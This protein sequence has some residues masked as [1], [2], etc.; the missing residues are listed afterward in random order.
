SPWAALR[1]H[2][3]VHAL[4]ADKVEVRTVDTE[5]AA[6]LPVSFAPPYRVTLEKG[7]VGELRLGALT[8]AADAEKDP[9]KKRALMDA[10]RDKDLVVKDIALRAEGDEKAWRIHE[11][12]AETPYGKGKLAGSVQTRK[13]FGLDATF[14][15]E[16]VAAER[17]WKAR[18]AAK[19]TLED[20]TANLEGEVSGQPATGSVR[21]EPFAEQPV[22]ALALEARGVDISKHADGP[23]TRLDVNVD[24]TAARKAF[25]GPVRIVNAEPGAWDKG[26][27]PFASAGARVVVTAERLDLHDLEVV[28]A[29][30]GR[31]AGRATV[32]RAGAEANL[33]VSDVNLAALHGNLQPTKVTGRIAATGDTRA[34]HFEVALKDP[35]F[36]I[37][38][39]AQLTPQR[40]D[41]E[42]A[43]VRTSGGAVTAK[44][45][46][47]LAGKREF[48]FEG[49]ARHFDPSAFVKT[50]KGD[51]NFAFVTSGTLS[52]EI[53]GEARLDLTPSTV[54]GLPASGRVN[55]AGD[56]RRVANLDMDVTVGEARAQAKGSF[57]LAGDA[58]DFRFN[59]PNLSTIARPLGVAAAGKVE[60][61]GRLTGTFASPAGRVSLTGANLVL[62]SNVYVRELSARLEAGVEATSPID[63]T[64]RA[65][66]IA[67]G[68]ETPPTP[69][70]QEATV[71]L[72]GTREAHRIEATALM[73]RDA[74]LRAA[75]QGGLDP[76]AK[77]PAWN[78]RVESLALTGAGAFS[79]VQPTTL[80]ASAERVELG[81]AQ[82]KGDW[83]EARFMVTRWTPRTLDLKGSS[84]GIQVQNFARSFRFATVPRSDLVVAVDW[85][86]HAAEQLDASAHLRRVS[87]D[88]RV[89]EPTLPLG[90]ETLEAKVEVV[91]GRAQASV[92]MIG[93]RV[94]KIEGSGST[95]LGHSAN[96]WRP[97]PDAPIEAKL[98]AEHTNLEALAPWLGPDARIGGRLNATVLVE[99]TGA[100]PRVSGTA[101]AVDLAVREP[102][103]GFEVERGQIA[104]KLTG[105]SAVI[106]QFEAVTPWRPS[107]GALARM[108]RVDVPPQGGRITASGSLDLAGRTGAIT[109]KLDKVPATQLASRFLA[110]S[111][112][113]QLKA[114]A[115]DLLVTGA[116]K[117]DAGWIGAL[118]TPPPSPS[119]DIVVVRA[120]K[121]A[122]IDGEPPKEPI[123]L[124]L[125]LNAGE[126]LYFQG[127]GLD[128]R[129]A[130]EVHLTGTPGVGLKAEGTI[131]TVAGTY[132]GYGQKLTIE[133]GVLTFQ[134]PLDN[135]RLNVLALRKGLPVEAGVEVLGT[136]TRPR[137]RLVSVP[138]VPEPEKLSWLVLGRGAADASLGDSAVMVAAAQAL[139]GNN[140]PGSDITKKIGIDDI[141]IGRADTSVLGVLPQSTV[142]GRTGTPSASEV[143]TV[144][145]R[146][147]RQLYLSYEQGLAD[148]EGTLKL[149]WRLTRHFQLLARAGYLPGLD[150]VYRWTFP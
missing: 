3:V 33:E 25:A 1:R 108:R 20:L 107:E 148:A 28:L 117:A 120:A 21:V 15:G 74:T 95:R 51:L 18:V 39:G 89:G 79:L 128:T 10:S 52:P 92:R 48:R 97:A 109:L 130:G 144:G 80:S 72:K 88:L 103:T 121:P 62:P 134:G 17:P 59:A 26:K 143:V 105:R 125:R 146:L 64:I 67:L 19:G 23:S 55:V 94:G 47:A 7:R 53:A 14:E 99:G 45:G 24:L 111:G 147:N 70:A 9:Q 54:A 96:G 37:E 13:P 135:P 6:K 106:E 49:E 66:G 78:G 57:G 31:A 104:V 63:G 140:N 137:V 133:R 112:D 22:R 113:V 58:M 131:R 30:G 38:G 32:T 71:S 68:E 36:A 29:G 84:A 40:L 123:R 87:G 114:G 60:G 122:P 127:R 65:K 4:E 11:A 132:D 136:T 115:R 139:L 56:Q 12:A 141:K 76:K 43:T 16:G 110:L 149:A 129:L 27:L 44:G 42:T 124:D 82:L 100:D 5:E 41:I 145:K 73:R 118:D 69:F 8:K 83:G 2:I 81:D 86:V 102:T 142:A 34:Q 85:D 101:R 93:Q 61:E 90:L 77:S 50:T 150:A 126:R 138:D 116:L 75:L 46:L 35:R 98:V 91:R 119:E